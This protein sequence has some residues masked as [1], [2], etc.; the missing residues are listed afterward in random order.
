MPHTPHSYR[1]DLEH[2]EQRLIDEY[3][4]KVLRPLISAGKATREQNQ[5]SA[6]GRGDCP[7]L[8]P[9]PAPSRLGEPGLVVS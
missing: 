2:A 4:Q 9:S 8:S 6:G 1:S 7:R 5:R 3:E